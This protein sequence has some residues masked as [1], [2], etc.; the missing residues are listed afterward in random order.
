MTQRV[1]RPMKFAA[2]ISII[3]S[4]AVMLAACQGAVGKAGEKGDMSDDITAKLDGTMLTLTPVADSAHVINV[5]SVEIT[6]AE[7]S[8]ISLMVRARRNRV[9]T[10]T[11]TA[12]NTEVVGTQAPAE[13][14]DM[15]GDCPAANE[16]VVEFTFVDADNTAGEDKLTFTATSADPSKVEVIKVET[17]TTGL[18]A[19]V[20]LKG[21][22]STWVED[23]NAEQEDNQP[24]HERVKIAVT[25]MDADRQVAVYASGD[26]EGDPGEGVINIAVDGAPTAKTLPGGTLSQTASTYVIENVTGFFTNPEDIE[27]DGEILVFS[28][29]SSDTNVATVGFGDQG[30]DAMGT[31]L[32][33]T[34]NAP[35]TATIT[36]TATEDDG[37]SPPDQ[38]AEGTFTITVSN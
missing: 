34:R 11:P 6:D 20:F 36:V 33:V 4:V 32:V 35:G 17:D 7:D 27:T 21:I 8:N 31:Q 13:A 19:R 25:G 1:A 26:N 30:T 28:A 16:C 5:F 24:G 38:T 15:T 12:D 14:P 3:I 9:P 29:K 22:S 23:A 18:I 37:D 2:F 10:V